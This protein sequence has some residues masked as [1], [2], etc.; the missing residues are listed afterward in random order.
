M[1]LPIKIQLRNVTGLHHSCAQKKPDQH[2]TQ[3]PNNLH[4]TPLLLPLSWKNTGTTKTVWVIS[5]LNDS[6]TRF[7]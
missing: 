3:P 4:T 1:K 7:P 2:N 5:K 6:S